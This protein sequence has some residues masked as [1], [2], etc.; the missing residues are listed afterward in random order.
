MPIPILSIVRS[1]GVPELSTGN[2]LVFPDS[3]S[4]PGTVSG[5]ASVSILSRRQ[6]KAN[7]EVNRLPCSPVHLLP[8]P[9]LSAARLL[10]F[11]LG[12]AHDDFSSLALSPASVVVLALPK[13]GGCS[14]VPD[15]SERER[16]NLID[17]QIEEDSR[18]F[19]K[20]CKILLLGASNAAQ[21][22]V[23]MH[24]LT[25]HRLWRVWKVNNRQANEDHT[26]EWL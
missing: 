9:T 7:L 6:R 25:L 12:P 2:S 18:Q 11:Q 24:P 19:K 17:K 21:A 16:S 13:M 22:P 26:S 8:A 1:S 23:Y 20:E 15:K 4:K 3:F 10:Y 14:S 5:W